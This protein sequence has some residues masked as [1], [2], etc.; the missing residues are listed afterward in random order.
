M[1][2]IE[3]EGTFV[4][5]PAGVYL[6]GFDGKLSTAATFRFAI[7]Q[8]IVDGKRIDIVEQRLEVYGDYFIIGTNGQPNET[9]CKQLAKSLGWN[10]DLASVDIANW[11][12]KCV[13]IDVKRDEY[14]GTVRF[15]ATWMRPWD[16]TPSGGQ[17]KLDVDAV[18]AINQRVGPQIRAMLG[19][20]NVGAPAPAKP[21]DVTAPYAPP[22]EPMTP[23]RPAAPA[24]PT[25]D[26]IPF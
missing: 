11:D 6:K 21:I 22:V 4:A 18:R 9:A 14:E 2:R 24:P 10:G 7:S 25:G 17:G 26:D 5:Y 12:D 23:A 8:E 1:P 3:R 13:Q 16:A 19:E 20:Q 15:K